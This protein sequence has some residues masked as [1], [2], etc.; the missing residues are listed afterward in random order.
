MM[1]MTRAHEKQ[2]VHKV[3]TTMSNTPKHQY[4]STSTHSRRTT[5]QRTL[6]VALDDFFVFAALDV[7]GADFAATGTS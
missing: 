7:D 2:C 4:P 3:H 5:H 1:D 6:A